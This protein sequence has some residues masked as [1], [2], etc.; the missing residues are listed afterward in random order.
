MECSM[1]VYLALK[2][3]CILYGAVKLVKLFIS[4]THIFIPKS[5]ILFRW[6]IEQRPHLLFNSIWGGV[7]K[8]IV[9]KISDENTIDEKKKNS[10]SLIPI[11]SALLKWRVTTL[12]MLSFSHRFNSSKY[13]STLQCFTNIPCSTTCKTSQFI[14]LGMVWVSMQL[15]HDNS[16]TQ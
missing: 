14:K 5:S 4:V 1:M 16:I 11:V 3:S 15:K 6:D 9:H 8:K 12:S 10:G 13:T 7:K 2:K